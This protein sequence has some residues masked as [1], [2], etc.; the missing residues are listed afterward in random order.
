MRFKP[1]FGRVR[2]VDSVKCRCRLAFQGIETVL[3]VSQLS[4]DTGQMSR[5]RKLVMSVVA[6]QPTTHDRVVDYLGV[7]LLNLAIS[8]YSTENF[9]AGKVAIAIV[10]K[11]LVEN[12]TTRASQGTNCFLIN[13]L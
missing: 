11:W 2:I 9:P 13:Q 10:A 3:Q 4:T 7:L 1:F 8:L 12:E 6:S 5:T